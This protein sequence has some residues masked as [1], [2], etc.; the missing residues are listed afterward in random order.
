MRKEYG[1]INSERLWIGD[2]TVASDLAKEASN[3]YKMA[4]KGQIATG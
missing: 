3:S 1:K 2:S 4:W